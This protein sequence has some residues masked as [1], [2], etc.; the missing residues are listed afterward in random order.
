MEQ[1]NVQIGDS[2][3]NLKLSVEVENGI[4]SVSV[5]FEFMPLE[6][7]EGVF[8]I[9]SFAEQMYS[10]AEAH[11]KTQFVF[12]IDRFLSEM[13]YQKSET[14]HQTNR[15][16][17]DE[18]LDFCKGYNLKPISHYEFLE[19]L[20]SLGFKVRRRMTNNG[21]FVYCKKGEATL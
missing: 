16:L 20:E 3:A 11:L 13:N 2:S 8:D 10:L 17:Y 7:K 21:I 4:I 1:E 19:R 15:F 18:Y 14:E 12:G 6:G 9:S 5:R